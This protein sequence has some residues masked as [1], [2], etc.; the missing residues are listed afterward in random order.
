MQKLMKSALSELAFGEPTLP[1]KTSTGPTPTKIDN[2]ELLHEFKSRIQY[3]K[4][5]VDDEYVPL[6]NYLENLELTCG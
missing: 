2:D 6:D 1:K 5:K 3:G 4:K